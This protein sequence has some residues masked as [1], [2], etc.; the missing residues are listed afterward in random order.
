M[1]EAS[2]TCVCCGEREGDLISFDDCSARFLEDGC[3]GDDMSERDMT[4]P[5]GSSDKVD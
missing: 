2:I 4:L 3:G 5:L 1:R